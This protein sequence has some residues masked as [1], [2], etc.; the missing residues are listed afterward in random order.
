MSPEPVTVV[1]AD[2]QAAVREGL[3]LL[4]GTLPGIAV[5]GEAADGERAVEVVAATD[6]QVVLM[7]L[8][9]PVCDGVEATR[10]IRAAHPR[11]QVVVLTTY[12]DDDSIIGALQAGALGYLTKDAT[13]AE[14]GRAVLAA[15]AGQAVL[16]PGVQQRLL[17][18]ATR[19]T[20]RG[21][22]S[23]TPRGVPSG[24]EPPDGQADGDLTPRESEVL[25]L[26]ATGRSNREIAKVLFVS[27]ATVKT[28]VNRIF[29]KTGSRDRSQAVSYAYAHGY[30][31]P[32]PR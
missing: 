11:T 7:D 10:R 14:I 28:H 29:A 16:D 18:A 31:T 8:N 15:A 5:A 13:R 17:F 19:G 12:S 25:R 6:P 20:P 30:A 2:D 32:P 21:V 1:V 9:M 3:V 23:G 27:E 22:P 4:L 24:A 26:I